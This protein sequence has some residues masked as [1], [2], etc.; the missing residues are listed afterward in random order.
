MMDAIAKRYPGGL[1]NQE[2]LM[3]CARHYWHIDFNGIKGTPSC[4]GVIQS[5]LE[6]G[7]DVWIRAGSS[8]ITD[9]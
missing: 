9:R 5:I 4:M 2:S 3:R 7:D 8:S 6:S 1:C